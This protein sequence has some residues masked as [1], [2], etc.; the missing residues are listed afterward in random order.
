MNLQ[1]PVFADLNG[2]GLPDVLVTV[3]TEVKQQEL[4]ALDGRKGWA[5]WKAALPVDTQAVALACLRTQANADGPA[6]VV[7]TSRFE[8]EEE[9]RPDGTRVPLP[10]ADWAALPPTEPR[11]TVRVERVRVSL[12]G[13]A[14]GQEKWTW[15]GAE[16]TEFTCAQ[17]V[18]ADLDGDGRP[19]VCVAVREKGS[20][21]TQIVVL[22]LQGQPRH[23]L[24]VHPQKDA[25]FRVWSHDLDGNSRE[26]L[27]LVGDG[28]VQAIG[29]NFD[30]P[31]W[32][33]PFPGDHGQIVAI[34]PAGDG[35]RAVVVVLAG[36]D[37]YSSD[38]HLYGLDGANGKP[39]WQRAVPRDVEGAFRGVIAWQ[40]G[41]Q[42][43]FAW[44][45]PLGFRD[46]EGDSPISG[47][48][49]SMVARKLGQSPGSAGEPAGDQRPSAPTL[50]VMNAPGIVY[51]LDSRT[52]QTLWRCS[53]PGR[54]I[55]LSPDDNP[56]DLPSVWY[57]TFKPEGTTIC[58]VALPVDSN[59]K[60]IQPPA[61]PVAFGPPPVD[62]WVVRP[63][64]W[65]NQARKR[66]SYALLP[67]LPGVGGLLCRAAEVVGR[68]RAGGLPGGRPAAG[69]V[70][71]IEIRLLVP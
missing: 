69:R 56:G 67:G 40:P 21:T 44:G 48:M 42:G 43:V 68:H 51:G 25:P 32:Q 38:K 52:G 45:G 65:E 71:G 47:T 11:H 17:P 66:L 12:L 20:E 30:K 3:Q 1:Q 16:G 62:N 33:W 6:D 49:Q 5:I 22:D 2:D 35:H 61:T 41:T 36:K 58:R 64:P 46:A 59:G 4:R 70:G 13:G 54:A 37:V 27:L 14:D 29:G 23:T 19:A 9:I 26:E 34:R 7:V 53:G 18:L 63:L 15:S 10:E 50:V 28:K 60:Y 8:R 31:L 57:H 39:L 24:R 55:G